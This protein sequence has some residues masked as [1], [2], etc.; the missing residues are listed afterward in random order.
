MNQQPPTLEQQRLIVAML[1]GGSARPL[2]AG[3]YTPPIMGTLLDAL[4]GE[5][6]KGTAKGSQVIHPDGRKVENK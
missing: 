6:V 1:N 2:R 5:E 4:V 3:S